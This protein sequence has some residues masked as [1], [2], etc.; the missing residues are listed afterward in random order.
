MV[1]ML[2]LLHDFLSQGFFS[3]GSRY[4]L[5]CQSFNRF[6]SRAPRL[7]VGHGFTWEL[8]PWAA[9]G[10]QGVSRAARQ[11]SAQAGT[12]WPGLGF[13]VSASPGELGIHRLDKGHGWRAQGAGVR[14]EMGAPEAAE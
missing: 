2:Q 7:S 5:L 12:A 3:C 13:G 4:D 1:V 8:L 11:G 14:Q 6:S 9:G 10:V